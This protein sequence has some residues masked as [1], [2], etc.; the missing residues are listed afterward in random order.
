MFFKS[1]DE[2]LKEIGFEK[3]NEDKYGCRYCRHDNKYNYNQIVNIAPEANGKLLLWSYDPDLFDTK[4]IGN[5]NVALTFY[6]IKLFY[7]KMK[8]LRRN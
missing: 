6:E 1:V 4:K 7:K 2:K 5:T 3:I 8:E